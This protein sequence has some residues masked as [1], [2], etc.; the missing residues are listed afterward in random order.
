MKLYT[1]AVCLLIAALSVGGTMLSCG[2]DSAQT[3]DT[4]ASVDTAAATEAVTEEPTALEKLPT[5]DYGGHTVNI[6]GVI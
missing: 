4:T 6:L 1:K 3:S 5:V 2:G